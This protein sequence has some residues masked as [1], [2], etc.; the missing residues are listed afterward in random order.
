MEI[1]ISVLLLLG[2]LFSNDSGQ[3]TPVPNVGPRGCPSC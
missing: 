3:T 1:L 2:G